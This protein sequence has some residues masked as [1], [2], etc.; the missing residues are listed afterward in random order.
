MQGNIF[1][2]GQEINLEHM[3][4][5]L[6]HINTKQAH[7]IVVTHSKYAYVQLLSS[8]VSLHLLQIRAAYWQCTVYH[9]PI[10]LLKYLSIASKVFAADL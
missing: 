7:C 1:D 5:S 10:V 8:L 3:L 2:Y 4:I 6:T 9:I